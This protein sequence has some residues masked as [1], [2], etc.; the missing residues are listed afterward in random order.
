M[1]NVDGYTELLKLLVS[2]VIPVIKASAAFIGRLDAFP[3]HCGMA[4]RMWN[5][6][7]DAEE[8]S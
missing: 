5:S 6:S 7:S 2:V 4:F 1:L 8:M 3:S